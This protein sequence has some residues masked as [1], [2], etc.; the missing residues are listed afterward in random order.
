[1]NKKEIKER[2]S[3]EIVEKDTVERD[4]N[5]SMWKE[6]VERDSTGALRANNEICNNNVSTSAK[7]LFW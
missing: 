2:D 5:E 6:T 7:Q 4:S 3:N 1:M